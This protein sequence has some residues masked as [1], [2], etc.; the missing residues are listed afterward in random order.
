MSHQAQAGQLCRDNRGQA[1]ACVC[2]VCVWCAR[3]KLARNLQVRMLA[4]V[5]AECTG[6]CVCVQVSVLEQSYCVHDT[7]EE[8]TCQ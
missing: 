1:P 3:V 8:I 2:V 7:G 6:V 5:C 4:Y